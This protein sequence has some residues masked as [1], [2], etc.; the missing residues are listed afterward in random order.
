MDYTSPITIWDT[1]NRTYTAVSTEDDNYIL[2]P[3]QA[4]FIQKPVEMKEISF[5]AEGRQ[6]NATVRQRTTTRS[7][8]SP[9]R[10]VFNFTLNDDTYTDRTRVVINP[11]ASM[12]YEMSRD[13]AKFMSDDKRRATTLH[14]GRYWQ[15]LRHQRTTVEQRNCLRRH[16]R[17]K[18]R[19]IYPE[20][21]R[22]HGYSRRSDINR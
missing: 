2:S 7:T 12:D 18:S 11:E 16:L 8:V 4:F 17:R 15:I 1:C 6:L 20:S 13:A 9:N 21:G 14:I 10:T 19:H 22:R 5:S 3:M